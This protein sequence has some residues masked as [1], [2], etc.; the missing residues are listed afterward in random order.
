MHLEHWVWE[1]ASAVLEAL[2]V[3]PWWQSEGDWA[4]APAVC[5]RLAPRALSCLQRLQGGI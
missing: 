4:R 5:C 1:P 3:L 2:G